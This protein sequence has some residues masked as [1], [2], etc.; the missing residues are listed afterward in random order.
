MTG[1]RTR[2]ELEPRETLLE[3]A[4]RPAVVCWELFDGH[5]D[6]VERADVTDFHLLPVFDLQ[7]PQRQALRATDVGPV[8]IDPATAFRVE[9]SASTN[10]AWNTIAEKLR[11]RLPDQLCFH[12]PDRE[13]IDAAGATSAPTLE[14]VRVQEMESPCLALD[15]G[16]QGL[17]DQSIAFRYAS[18][19]LIGAPLSVSAIGRP[20]GER[21]DSDGSM[22]RT[23][24][25]VAARFGTLTRSFVTFS[26]FASVSP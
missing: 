8:R 22:P 15:V 23:V 12:V 10:L 14:V 6:H 17:H 3:R 24:A 11:V 4:E 1:G 5:L 20:T 16:V 26:P 19:A 9:E 7:P 18:K 13:V 25:I 21:N 2:L